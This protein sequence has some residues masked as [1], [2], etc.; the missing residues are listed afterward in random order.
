[1]GKVKKTVPRVTNTVANAINTALNSVA[2]VIAD[3]PETAGNAIEDGANVASVWVAKI[4]PRW[5]VR[6]RG[7]YAG[8]EG[9]RLPPSILLARS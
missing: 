5:A 7:D 6:S 2:E 4:I 8:W 3:V 1:M 9:F